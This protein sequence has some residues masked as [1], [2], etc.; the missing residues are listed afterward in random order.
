MCVNISHFNAAVDFWALPTKIS[1]QNVGLI[2]PFDTKHQNRLS[3]TNSA[4][5][6]YIWKKSNVFQYG[7]LQIYNRV[8][9]C[10][11]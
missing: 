6:V 1:T 8:I 5:S 9:E 2:Y 10:A 4:L 11:L 7:L 3:G